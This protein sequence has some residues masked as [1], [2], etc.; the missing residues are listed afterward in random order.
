MLVGGVVKSAP[1]IESPIR[2]GRALI[3]PGA[4]SPEHQAHE[5]AAIA[6]VL[7][8]GALPPGGTIEGDRWIPR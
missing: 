5:V 3:T 4:G 2:G 6:A 8:L 1:V 7:K